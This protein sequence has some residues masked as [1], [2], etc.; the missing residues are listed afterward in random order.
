MLSTYNN[1]RS[2]FQW[3]LKQA[4]F[5]LY[6]RL[7]LFIFLIFLQTVDYLVASSISFAFDTNQLTVSANRYHYSA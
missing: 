6:L 2:L 5:F 7:F 3:A 4:S 1:Q